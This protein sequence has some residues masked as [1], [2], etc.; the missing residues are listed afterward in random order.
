VSTLSIGNLSGVGQDTA[1]DGEPIADRYTLERTIGAG[2][3]A[4]VYEGR[5]LAADRAVA[6]KV[7]RH[8]GSPLSRNRELAALAK[9]HH[10]NLV[11]LYDGGTETGPDGRT[12]LVTDLV[13]GPTLAERLQEG[14]LDARE[15]LDLGAGLASALAHV[16][17]RGFIHRDIKP[18]N[19]LLEHGREPRLA[20]FGIARALDSTVATATGAV[21]GTA[22]YLAPEQARG[23]KVDAAADV[24]ALGL[25]LLEAL[26]GR[27]EFPG[28]A[29]ESATAR[30][31]R[32]PDVPPGLPWNL[33]GLLES[34]TDLDP[35]ARP[36]AK[37][38][39]ATLSSLIAP[40][41]G[42]TRRRSMPALVAAALLLA[43]LI[44]GAS[45]LLAPSRTISAPTKEATPPSALVEAVPGAEPMTPAPVDDVIVTP[46][47]S[48]PE[49]AASLDLRPTGQSGN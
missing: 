7:Y 24:Y 16:H 42:R 17:A 8:G 39:A 27:R 43:C 32:R 19:I 48:R 9:L 35:A 38:V 49:N 3:A 31:Y 6:V 44:G 46:T 28:T 47:A 13:D 36:T 21:S 1:P 2:A 23:D 5:D 45:L 26:T 34:M 33:T 12:Y 11:T 20:D 22:A 37:T 4:V 29:I 10:E 25:V 40:E 30:L 14:P 15:V 18:A 41:P